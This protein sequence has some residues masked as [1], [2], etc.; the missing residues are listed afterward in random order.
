MVIFVDFQ[1]CVVD[2]SGDSFKA[3]RI[4]VSHCINLVDR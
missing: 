2:S 4:V 3:V 1:R